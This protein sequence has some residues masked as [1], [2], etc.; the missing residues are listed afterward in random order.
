MG[1]EREES[2]HSEKHCVSLALGHREGK[3]EVKEKSSQALVLVRC[4]TESPLQSA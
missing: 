1:R 2:R 3:E 4:S